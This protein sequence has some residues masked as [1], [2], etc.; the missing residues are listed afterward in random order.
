MTNENA[1][2]TVRRLLHWLGGMSGPRHE[3]DCNECTA[4][5]QVCGL[6]GEAAQRHANKAKKLG[7]AELKVQ[8]EGATVIPP[9]PGEEL[10]EHTQPAE[11]SK[12]EQWPESRCA[13]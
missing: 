8:V 5:R 13:P 4:I 10:P 9:A 6:A 2:A 12:A 3:C 1:I 11:C 7:Y